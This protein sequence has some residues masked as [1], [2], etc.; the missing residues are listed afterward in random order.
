M[1]KGA[2]RLAE[3]EPPVSDW[4]VSATAL[5]RTAAEL[6][7]STAEHISRAKSHRRQIDAASGARTIENTLVPYNEMMM[8]LDAASAECGLFRQVH[9]DAAVRD[10]ARAGEQNVAAY[11]IELNL[12]GGLYEA[13]R[14][15]DVT[16]A[17]A[18]TRYLVEKRLRDFRRAGVDK[19]ED[20][21]RRIAALHEELVKIGQ[22]FSKNITDD[23][24]RREITLDSPDDL[25]GLPRDW[26][27]KHPP[28]ADGRVHVTVRTPDYV[29][30]MTYARNGDARRRL[31]I[32]SRNRGYPANVEVLNRLLAKRSELVKLLGYPNYA[33]YITEDKMIA[34]AA[35][36]AGFIDQVSTLSRAAARREYDVLLARKRRDTP[37]SDKVD[38]WEKAYYEQIVMAEDYAYDPQA[39]RPY[40]NFPAVQDGLFRLT[41]QLLGLSYQSVPNLDLWHESV[42]AWDVLEDEQPIGRIYLDLHPRKD[43]Y[44][45]A[46]QF[47]Y[48]TG[49]G[50]R[51]LPQAVLV[52]NFP[53]PS[54]SHGVALMEHDD[55]VTFFHEFGHLLHSLLAGRQR[56]IGNSG[57]STEWDFVEVPSQL[58]EEWCYDY[59]ALRTFARHH[60]TGES[61]PRHLVEA[62]RRAND[63]GKGLQAAQQMFYASVSLQYHCR[64]P[65]NLDTMQLM[66]DLQ[67]KYS[68]FDYVPDT[69][70]QCSFGHLDGYS[71]IYYTYMW[72]KVIAKDMFSRFEREGILHRGTAREY[73]DNVLA[74]GGSKKA[75][76]LVES[77]LGRPYS[78]AAFENWLNRT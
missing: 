31:F 45:H 20:V 67:R 22:E 44:G 68:L 32:E 34:S 72:S 62:L 58:L 40:F 64:E 4:G 42:T 52:C 25:A 43:K 26:I 55:V 36:A 46:A 3:L 77:F 10:A 7:A 73:R 60:Q 5:E 12:D 49:V 76:E 29:P 11:V 56:W 66:R 18:A 27:D 65:Q 54:E 21:R 41:G 8:H 30:F 39:V 37:E 53:D 71:A 15:V 19:P 35:N 69:H 6:S 28:G 70:F 14:C 2:A 59:D 38:D 50:G 63:F 74:P 17:D 51:R 47:D 57:I 13:L 24:N 1:I 61:I 48:R 33:D 23:E 16:S 75:S 78:F 9:P